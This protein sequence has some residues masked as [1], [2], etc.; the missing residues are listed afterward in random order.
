MNRRI[1]SRTDACAH[2]F[3]KGALPTEENFKP[4]MYL[5][6]EMLDRGIRVQDIL[7]AFVLKEFPK[8]ITGLLCWWESRN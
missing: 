4:D 2:C 6:H 5:V 3:R 7:N 1:E 8:E